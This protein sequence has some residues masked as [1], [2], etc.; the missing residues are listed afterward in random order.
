MTN[1]PIG[2]NPPAVSG[3]PSSNNNSR[4]PAQPQPIPLA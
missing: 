2:S 3:N 4:F 1:K